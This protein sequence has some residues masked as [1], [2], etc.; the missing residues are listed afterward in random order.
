MKYNVICVRTGPDTDPTADEIWA[1]LPKKCS[2]WESQY[3]AKEYAK[4][5]GMGST[6]YWKPDV[7]GECG[8][9]IDDIIVNKKDAVQSGLMTDRPPVYIKPFYTFLA[10]RS[11][12][13]AKTR[14]ALKKKMNALKIKAGHI[15]IDRTAGGKRVKVEKVNRT[16]V[17]TMGGTTYPISRLSKK[18][19]RT[20]IWK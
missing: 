16:R 10:A 15:I 9:I 1:S 13:N 12:V 3:Y 11:Q 5:L 17:L 18:T 4:H 2:R 14:A 8:P 20:F 19:N 6:F 7:M